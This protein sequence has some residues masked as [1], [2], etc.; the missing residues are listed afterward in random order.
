MCSRAVRFFNI[1]LASAATAA[2]AFAAPTHAVADPKQHALDRLEALSLAPTGPAF[3]RLVA[4]SHQ[5]IVDLFLKAGI[6]VNA[7]GEGGRTALLA[8]TL[9]R[10]WQTAD[11]LLK[12]GAETN[13]GDDVGVTP[14]MAAAM[15]GHIPAMQNLLSHGADPAAVDRRGHTALHYAVVAKK[16]GAIARLLQLQPSLPGACCEGENL[17]S[18]ALATKDPLI[19]EP[20][21]SRTPALSNWSAAACEALN[22]ALTG[23]Q[24]ATAKLLISRHTAPPVPAQ[25][26]QPFIAYA[27]VRGDASLLSRLIECGADPNVILDQPNDAIFNDLVAQSFVR[28]YLAKEPGF[29]ALMLAAGMGRVECVKL[30]LEKGAKRLQGTDGRSRLLPLYFAAW[31]A[32]PEAVQLLVGTNPPPRE[33]LR[34]E[35]DL[36]SQRATVLKASVP[37]YE[38]AISSGTYK[39]PTPIGEFVITDKHRDHRSSIYDSAPMP[40]FMRL[41][42]RDFGLHQGHV[43]GRPASHGCIRLPGG[44][45]RKLFAELPI[46]TWV[47]IVN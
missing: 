33:E 21:L 24:I 46:G 44:A 5:S 25:S 28:H 18:H 29:T 13:R 11:R 6:D 31:A 37:I 47:S 30:L 45:A 38:T 40:F 39:K 1:R 26:A 7:T 23:N 16:H 32:C 36:S 12:K 35:V 4:A 43:T 20:I 9:A 14:L 15:N 2:A 17:V 41:S 10:D 22:S 34:V 42:C 3:V 27:V 19:V 8:A